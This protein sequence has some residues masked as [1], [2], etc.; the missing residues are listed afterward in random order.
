MQ[1]LLKDAVNAKSS[2]KTPLR[3]EKLFLLT[4]PMK[5]ALNLLGLCSPVAFF[6]NALM[7]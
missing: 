2:N 5:S 6:P 7:S 1:G 3:L 4:P